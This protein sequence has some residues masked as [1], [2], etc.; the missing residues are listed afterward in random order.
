M[1]YR[2]K[3]ELIGERFD[4]ERLS[5]VFTTTTCMVVFQEQRAFLSSARFVPL[6]NGGDVLDAAERLVQQ[7]NGAMLV[8]LGDHVP[9]QLGAAF[10]G[11]P[12]GKSN[13]NIKIAETIS[14]STRLFPPALSGPGTTGLAPATAA[15]R[16][17]A[18]S[19]P[20]AAEVLRLLSQTAPDAFT[21]SKVIEIIGEH[22]IKRH[23]WVSTKQLGR[24][25]NSMN[26]QRVL[27]DGAR[28]ANTKHDP[29]KKP[30]LLDEARQFVREI[31]HKFVLWCGSGR[32]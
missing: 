6:T 25:S 26:N 3:V 18:D 2:W 20:D 4:L 19:D 29:P 30:M 27:G 31:A 10:E 15:L 7:I 9:V 24:F 32:P 23:R 17:A 5:Q 11:D 8:Q 12:F 13:I 21:L 1:P 14:C 22:T 16:D 28:H